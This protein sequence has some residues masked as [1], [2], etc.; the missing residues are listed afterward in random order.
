MTVNIV[1]LA[2]QLFKHP[3]TPETILF[4]FLVLAHTHTH[5]HTH[6]AQQPSTDNNINTKR[7]TLRRY[8]SFD[9]VIQLFLKI[10][11]N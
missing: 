1:K 8:A 2:I 3:A 10:K 6:F 5:G 4:N 9:R 7:H 11:K